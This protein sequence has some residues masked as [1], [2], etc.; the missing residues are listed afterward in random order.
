VTVRHLTSQDATQAGWTLIRS[1]TG[2]PRFMDKDGRLWAR[3]RPEWAELFI[4]DVPLRWLMHTA[5]LLA[6]MGADIHSKR[7]PY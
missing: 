3:T 2:R 4:A 1:H 7:G 6:M 5:G